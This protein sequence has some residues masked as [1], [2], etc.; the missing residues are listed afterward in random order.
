MPHALNRGLGYNEF[1]DPTNYMVNNW[2]FS[3]GVG[4]KSF[5]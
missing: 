4:L 5:W 1:P 2:Q 3:T